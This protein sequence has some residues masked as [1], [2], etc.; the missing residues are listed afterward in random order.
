MSETQKASL[1]LQFLV[2]RLELPGGMVEG[3]AHNGQFVVSSNIDLVLK[4]AER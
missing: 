3:P 2:E 1:L 4:I